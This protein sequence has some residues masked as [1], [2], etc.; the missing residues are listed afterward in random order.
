RLDRTAAG[1]RGVTVV[2]VRRGQICVHFASNHLY[3][4][5]CTE[6]TPDPAERLAAHPPTL[7]ARETAGGFRD[8]QIP[9]RE[10]TRR[11]PPKTGHSS[12]IKW[13]SCRRS[14]RENEWWSR[15]ATV[16]STRVARCSGA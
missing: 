10:A 1:L 6:D 14:T 7:T 4:P 16:G 2:F 8:L 15:S 9:S 12:K 5:A 13:P 11:N 3:A